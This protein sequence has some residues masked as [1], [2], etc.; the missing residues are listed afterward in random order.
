VAHWSSRHKV[1]RA[2]TDTGQTTVTVRVLLR[3]D[4]SRI[5]SPAGDETVTVGS[6]QTDGATV[7]IHDEAGFRVEVEVG[8]W[9]AVTGRGSPAPS[10][11]VF[12]TAQPI[13]ELLIRKVNGSPF[14]F[15]SLDLSGTTAIPPQVNGYLSGQPVFAYSDQLS[16]MSGGFLTSSNGSE[17]AAIDLLAIKV[18]SPTGGVNPMGV[19]TIRLR[20]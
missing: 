11:Q 2:G 16:S 17:D 13:G 3:I 6:L 12:G 10:I 1:R 18:T 14:W 7:R 20:R 5:P 15:T 9:V 4:P 8:E 19:D